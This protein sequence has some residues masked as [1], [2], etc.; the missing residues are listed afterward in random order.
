[1]LYSNI[2]AFLDGQTKSD[3]LNKILFKYSLVFEFQ[4]YWTVYLFHFWCIAIVV[5]AKY[6]S[7]LIEQMESINTI[8]KQKLLQSHAMLFCGSFLYPDVFD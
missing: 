2:K 7:V 8:K 3:I 6:V 5:Q 4:L 1:M